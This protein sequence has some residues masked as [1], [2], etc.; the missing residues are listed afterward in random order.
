[1]FNCLIGSEIVEII[2]HD[3]II[4]ITDHSITKYLLMFERKR[5]LIYF[6]FFSIHNGN[7]LNAILLRQSSNFAP[8]D[9]QTK[10]C[11]RVINSIW[12]LGLNNQ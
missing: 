9:R 4:L 11:L 10:T 3:F 5:R 7:N 8:T 12:G 6:Y 1:M 2:H